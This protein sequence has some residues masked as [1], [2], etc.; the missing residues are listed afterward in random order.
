ML[1]GQENFSTGAIIQHAAAHQLHVDPGDGGK[2]FKEAAVL[3]N[4]LQNSRNLRLGNIMLLLPFGI[5]DNHVVARSMSAFA[6][7]VAGAVT[8]GAR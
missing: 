1:F 7:V 5:A 4:S 3:G 2:N 8:A 6:A